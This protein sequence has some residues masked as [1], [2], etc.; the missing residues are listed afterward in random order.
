MRIN[1]KGQVTIPASIREQARL[2]PNTEVEFAYDGLGQVRLFRA[3]RKARKKSRGE[4]LVE[5]MQGKG[6]IRITTDEIMALTRG[7]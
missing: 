4:A 5:Q 2:L 3:H 6:D 7:T 1:S